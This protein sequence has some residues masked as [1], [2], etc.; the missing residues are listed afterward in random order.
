VTDLHGSVNGLS[1]YCLLSI[2]LG[3]WEAAFAVQEEGRVLRCASS[4]CMI[5]LS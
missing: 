1:D 4:G 2:A 3:K 5:R